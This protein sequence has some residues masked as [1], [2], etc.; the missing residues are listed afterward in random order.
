MF[1]KYGSYTTLELAKA[2]CISDSKCEAVVN[3]DCDNADSASIALCSLKA[4][5]T[6][7]KQ[8]CVYVKKRTLLIE[9]L[10]RNFRRDCH[11]NLGLKSNEL[12]S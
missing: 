5:F 4:T 10:I 3:N 1:D 7:S 6:R 2:E 8:S 9:L 11:F 12:K